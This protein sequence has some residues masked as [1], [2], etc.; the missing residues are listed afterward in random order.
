MYNELKNR[1][2]KHEG[3]RDVM[4]LDSLGKKTIGYGHLVTE[5]GIL[6]GI[7]YS[8]KE[9]D[10]LF[11]KD[12]LIALRDATKLVSHLDLPNEAFNVVIEMCFQLGLSKVT[13]FVNFLDALK[14]YDY[15][16]AANE[17]LLS[18]WYEQTPARCQE[19]SNIIRS[20]E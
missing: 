5:D 3:F 19:L 18:K 10:E 9:L 1:I 15:N 14:K 13:K 4:Y 7:Q 16:R 17:M 11:E 20:C 2:K 6:P 12:F 8:K